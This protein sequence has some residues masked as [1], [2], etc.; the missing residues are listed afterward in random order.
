MDLA[1]YADLVVELVN[2]QDPAEDS[3]RDLDTLRELLTI[4]PHLT[5]RVTARDLELMRELRGDLRAIFTAAAAGDEEGAAEVLNSLLIQ[6]PVHPQ[7]SSHEGSPWHVHMTEGGSVP[8][9][10]AAGAA[11]GLAVLVSERGWDKLGICDRQG[12]GNVYFDALADT[13]L[14]YCSDRCHKLHIGGNGQ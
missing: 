10:Y 3:L 12:C 2:T 14:R 5:G 8:D 1:S 4:R 7:L 13:V 9:R 6:H 11:I